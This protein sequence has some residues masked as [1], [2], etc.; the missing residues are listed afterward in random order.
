MSGAANRGG[1]VSG[2]EEAARYMNGCVTP[3]FTV[4]LEQ[5]AEIDSFGVTEK[6]CGIVI[7]FTLDGRNT[8][9]HVECMAITTGTATR[10]GQHGAGK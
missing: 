7:F 10:R 3:Q 6:P 8:K 2:G 1:V 9:G 5:R 4:A